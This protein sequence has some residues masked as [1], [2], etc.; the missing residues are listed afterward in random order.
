MCEFGRKKD[1]FHQKESEI[2]LKLDGSSKSL[3]LDCIPDYR[4]T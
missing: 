2:L 1:D 4:W 3:W